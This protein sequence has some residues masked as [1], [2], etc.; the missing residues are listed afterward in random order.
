[1]YV[2]VPQAVAQLVKPGDEGDL[3]L[4]EFPGRTF[5]ARVTNTAVA[6]D[7]VSRAMVVELQ[8]PN[9]VG[10][11]LS[12]AYAQV[13]L[14]LT[15]ETGFYTIPANSLLFR[16]EGAAVGVVHPDG[17]VEIRKITL[18]LNQGNTLQIAGGLSE[19]D[20]VIVNPSDSLADGMSAKV[21]KPKEP[22]ASRNTASNE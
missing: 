14:K 4:S 19:T 7:P 12:G 9:E 10:E 22:A 13:T 17:K 15:G 11:L 16:A 1:V 2:N 6:I 21:L 18:N 5:P 3:R 20:Q 8:T